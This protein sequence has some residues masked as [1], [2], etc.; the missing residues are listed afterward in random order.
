MTTDRRPITRSAFHEVLIGLEY[1][2]DQEHPVDIFSRACVE[3]FEE[4]DW[5]RF[6]YRFTQVFEATVL[7]EIAVIERMRHE[8]LARLEH[9]PTAAMRRLGDALENRAELTLVERVNLASVLAGIA[10]PAS[11][12]IVLSETEPLAT[13]HRERFEIAWLAFILANRQD[14]TRRSA[15]AFA[16]MR[17]AITSGKVPPGRALDACAQGVVWYLKREEI[18]PDDFAWCLRVGHALATREEV[19]DLATV[20]S[21]YR[22]LAM[23]PASKGMPEK[24]RSYMESARTAAEETIRQRPRAYELN[25][26]KTY[27]ESSL[28]EHMYVTRDAGAAIESGRALIALDPAWS[29]SYGELAEVYVR[30][31]DSREAAELYDTAVAKGPPY[32]GHHLLKSATCW[33]KAGEPAQALARYEDLAALVPGDAE[34]LTSGLNCAR[35]LSHPSGR[36]FETALERLDSARAAS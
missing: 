11:A 26:L 1:T 29:I 35:R 28:K 6:G 33:E 14:D 22:G 21:W 25:L 3:A 5:T 17:A 34:V 2:D 19:Q 16:A 36:T 31:G 18:A 32:V 8:D 27:H 15:E 30:F 12:D 24:T 10:R 9:R 23:L 7:H 4:L 13:S 20:S